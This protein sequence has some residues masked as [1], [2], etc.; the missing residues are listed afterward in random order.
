[1]TYEEAVAILGEDQCAALRERLGPPK[2]LSPAQITLLVGLLTVD[3]D[4]SATDA[5]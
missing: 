4:A 3:L 2:P 5:A 1:M